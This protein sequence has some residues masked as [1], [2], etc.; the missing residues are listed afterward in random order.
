MKDE[1]KEPQT[2]KSAHRWS[3]TTKTIVVLF[4]VVLLSLIVYRFQDVIPPLAIALLL[5]FILDPIANFL[6]NRLR[7]SRGLAA[8]I[9]IL[10]LIIAMAGMAATPVAVV[11]SIRQAVE[12][13]QEETTGVINEIG[14]F[15][16]QPPITFLG[17]KLDLGE[18]YDELSQLLRSFVSSVAQETIDIAISIASGFLWLIFIL[19]IT[20]YLLKDADRLIEQLDKLPPQDYRQDFVRLRQQITEVWNAFLRGQLLLGVVIAIVTTAGCM[21]L[22]I[23]YAPVLGLLAGLL[24]VVP[25]I[26]PIIAAVPAI[27]LALFQENTLFGMSNF[28][29]AVLVAGMYIVIQQLENNLI[30]PRIMGRSLNLHPVLVLIAVVVGG[31]LGGVL[32][33]LL[34]APTLA[35]IRVIGRYIFC[36]VYDLDPFAETEVAAKAPPPPGLLE[37]M[38][39]AALNYVRQRG[40]EKPAVQD[41][42]SAD[43]APDD[44]APGASSGVAPNGADENA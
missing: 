43:D 2:I 25:S 33:I 26:G 7:L 20:F 40:S 35:T 17:Y 5:A 21:A 13:M 30:V 38:H 24:E 8:A 15:L 29:Y 41:A 16:N 14:S 1:T 11:P 12:S 31:S 6:T 18:F 28:W 22:G 10:V 39:K 37:R 19:M 3:S 23:Q 4:M 27:L 34:A 36:R 44:A 9:V 32:G 42:T